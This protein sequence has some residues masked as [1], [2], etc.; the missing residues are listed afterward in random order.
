MRIA[1]LQHKDSAV[2]NY[3]FDMPLSSLGAKKYKKVLNKNE[4]LTLQELA[5]KWKK[6][7]DVLVMKYIEDIHTLDVIYSMAKIA[8]IKVVVDVDDNMWQ[9]P[10]GNIA[11]GSEKENARRGIALTESVRAADWITVSTAPLKAIL[12][13]LNDNVVVLPNFINPDDWNFKRKKHKKVRIGWVYSPTHMPDII[14]VSEALEDI[15][16]KYGDAIEVVVFGTDKNIFK[17]D[18]LNIPAVK[19]TEYPRVFMEEGIDI[20]IAPLC[21]ND[22]NK[23][24]SNIKWLESTMAGACFIGSKVYPYMNSIKQGKTG[25]VCNGKNQWV[26]H[27]SHLIDNED[28]RKELV[29]NAKEEVL[30]N[31][32]NNKKH[33]DFY[34]NLCS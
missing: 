32:S 9:I 34:T 16:E 18:T 29:K 7:C 33:K 28:K 3:R 13:P 4:T 15:V 14:E 10:F 30:K 17:F 21:D 27:L 5:D 8:G 11:R 6:K 1:T 23:C 31:Y 19:Y 2:F 20:S 22:F 26:K 12:N 24:K 25:Y